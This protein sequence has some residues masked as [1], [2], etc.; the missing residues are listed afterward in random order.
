MNDD[1]VDATKD[2]VARLP[3]F[4]SIQLLS[5]VLTNGTQLS[6][7]KVDELLSFLAKAFVTDNKITIAIA[8]AFRKAQAECAAR[9]CRGAVAACAA[10]LC[11]VS[12]SGDG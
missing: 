8:A 1:I 3:N 4:K 9:E 5:D 12:V 2:L 6:E 7:K 10:R 11:D